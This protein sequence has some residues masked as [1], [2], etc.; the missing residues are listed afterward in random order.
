MK[1]FHLYA[2][3]PNQYTSHARGTPESNR[4]LP[5]YC[6]LYLPRRLSVHSKYV[7]YEIYPGC[8]LQLCNINSVLGQQPE[9]GRTIKQPV[10]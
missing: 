3:V 6:S 9:E 2:E 5:G 8:V 10:G 4:P 1:M 7:L